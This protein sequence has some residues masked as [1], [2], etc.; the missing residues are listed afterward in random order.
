MR[1]EGI[2]ARLEAGQA[3]EFPRDFGRFKLLRE[4]GRGARGI[5]YESI[6]SR[7]GRKAALKVMI[8]QSPLGTPESA[9]DTKAYIVAARLN[10][11]LP[12][13]PNVVAVY[14]ADEVQG[15]GYFSMEF[16]QGQPVSQWQRGERITVRDRVALV[17]TVALALEQAHLF[18]FLH[19]NIKPNNVIVDSNNAPHLT[20]F[21][22]DSTVKLGNGLSS[23]ALGLS[24]GV[25]TYLSPEQLMNQ[26]HIDRRSDVY[27]LGV[28][29]FEAVTGRAPFKAESTVKTLINVMNE[30]APKPSSC[31]LLP[32]A[33]PVDGR[34]DAIALRALS[35]E[36]SQRHPSAQALADELSKWLG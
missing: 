17:R 10:S 2:P 24:R 27:A 11:S 29:L 5:V 12:S 14:E 3:S 36:P 34:M 30:P 26:K 16:V 31:V 7:D 13:H 8:P 20:D 23:T 9:Q 22:P 19:S 35:K 32:N 15:R 4:V 25:L 21:R 33:P 6:D 18:G 28:M 1:I